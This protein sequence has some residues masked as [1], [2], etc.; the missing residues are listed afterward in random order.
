[1]EKLETR[2]KAVEARDR[3]VREEEEQRREAV[4]EMSVSNLAAVMP[5]WRTSV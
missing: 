2:M 4:Y 5:P 1:M 3:Q